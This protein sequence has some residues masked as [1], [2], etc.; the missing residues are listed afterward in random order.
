LNSHDLAS[1]ISKRAELL[2][3]LQRFCPAPHGD[4][5]ILRTCLWTR[6]QS[7]PRL[8]YLPLA[9]VAVAA[10]LLLWVFLTETKPAKY[11]D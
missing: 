6:L 10:T 7:G 8:G 11:E 1:L 2:A 5:S 4:L 9:V 3:A